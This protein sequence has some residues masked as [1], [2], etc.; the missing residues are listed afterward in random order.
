MVKWEAG[1]RSPAGTGRLDHPAPVQPSAELASGSRIRCIQ[2]KKKTSVSAPLSASMSIQYHCSHTG[3]TRVPCMYMA[4]GQ[5]VDTQL[6]A[7]DAAPEAHGGLYLIAAISLST[8]PHD[9][10]PSRE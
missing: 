5:P 2:T 10:Q 7:S 6:H 3:T 9:P 8:S 1:R 4:R